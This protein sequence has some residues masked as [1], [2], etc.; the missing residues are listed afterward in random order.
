MEV[1]SL[2]F[3]PANMDLHEE[4][5][6]RFTEETF[7]ESFGNA[8]RF[9]EEDGQGEV[10]YRQWLRDRLKNDPVSVVMV[11]RQSAIVGMITLGHWK[12]DP[13]VG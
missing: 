3:L 9:H 5:C 7:V 8:K 4:I 1:G 10:R 2:S 12:Q 11:L 13:S 6:V